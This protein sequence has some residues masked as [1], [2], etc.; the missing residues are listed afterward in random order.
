[1][2][3]TKRAARSL[4]Q[5]FNRKYAE[6]RPVK[7]SQV[8]FL[9]RF[10]FL[11]K[12]VKKHTKC[13]APAGANFSCKRKVSKGFNWVVQSC[14][15]GV[16]IRGLQNLETP[17]KGTFFVLFACTK[18]TKSTPEVCDL[19]TPG[20]IQSS[21]GN[22][23]AEISGGTCRNRFCPQNAGEEALNRCERVTVV[24]TQD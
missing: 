13:A 22:N 3:K 6:K 10:S 24:Q 5:D 1:M 19:W 17:C 7:F 8:G 4:K 20:T 23:F 16:L 18:R 15:L 2:R 21:A 9:C 14:C 11:R 12:V